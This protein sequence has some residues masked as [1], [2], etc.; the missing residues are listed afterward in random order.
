MCWSCLH[1]CKNTLCVVFL[2]LAQ[3]RVAVRYAHVFRHVLTRGFLLHKLVLREA[4]GLRPSTLQ[5][6]ID[7]PGVPCWSPKIC[8]PPPTSGFPQVE[9]N[10][11]TCKRRKSSRAAGIWGAGISVWLL[12]LRR[13]GARRR[14]AVRSRRTCILG[15]GGNRLTASRR[16]Q[17]KQG[18]RRSAAIPHHELSWQM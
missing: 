6:G 1:K 2:S 16:G 18:R 11:E 8:A 13:S 7:E 9:E 10:M 3:I 4:G 15:R 5:E 14:S 17:D 12:A